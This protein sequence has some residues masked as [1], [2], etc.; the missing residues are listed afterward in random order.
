MA[1]IGKWNE[2]TLRK[3]RE[4]FDSEVWAKTLAEAQQIKGEIIGVN[5]S[6]GI[7]E[8]AR[9][10]IAFVF[11]TTPEALTDEQAKAFFIASFERSIKI[12]LQVKRMREEWN[13]WTWRARSVAHWLSSWW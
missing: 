1:T 8:R 13:K 11:G 4:S 6:I 10:A 3:L 7:D 12:S 2:E 5:I 9:E